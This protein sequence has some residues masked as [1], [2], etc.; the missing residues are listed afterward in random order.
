MWQNGAME[1]H[2]V[3]SHVARTLEEL[4]RRLRQTKTS[5]REVE[6]I[7]GWS[8]GYLSQVFQGRITLTLAHVLSI[9]AAIE[10]SPAEFFRDLFADLQPLEMTDIRERLE[11]YDA[12]FD[13]L[14]RRG[15]LD[16]EPWKGKVGDP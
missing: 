8:R 7:C 13:E 14:R 15:L 9:L 11:Q 16:P 10:A 2:Q 3:D 1:L 12:A 6:R 5:Q 4:K